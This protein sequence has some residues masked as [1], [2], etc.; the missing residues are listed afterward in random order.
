MVKLIY[1]LKWK[2]LTVLVQNDLQNR[3]SRIG[4]STTEPWNHTDSVQCPVVRHPEQCNVY[5][6]GGG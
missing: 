6:K 5:W 2:G 4:R 1:L 3:L